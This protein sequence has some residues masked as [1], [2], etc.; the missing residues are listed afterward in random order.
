MGD[1]VGAPAEAPSVSLAKDT[2]VGLTVGSD[3]V[4]S[5][6]AIA[7]GATVGSALVTEIRGMD[8]GSMVGVGG[9]T[10]ALVGGTTVGVG[11]GNTG[12]GGL[13][14]GGEGGGRGGE[15]GGLAVGGFG[16]G[17]PPP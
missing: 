13:G 7:F 16:V 11:G 17:F 12:G 3:V 4:V 8:V 15:V 6:L 5:F 10:G 14:E 9:T 1:D 2:W